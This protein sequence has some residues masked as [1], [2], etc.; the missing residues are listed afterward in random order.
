MA[1]RNRLA[2][3]GGV[4]RTM[5]LRLLR[6]WQGPFE[7]AVLRGKWLTETSLIVRNTS[8]SLGELRGPAVV[9]ESLSHVR[10][11]VIESVSDSL[12]AVA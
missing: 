12:D 6:H 2:H 4:T 11:A 7:G 3:G 9:P 5:A 1:L 10:A 8:G